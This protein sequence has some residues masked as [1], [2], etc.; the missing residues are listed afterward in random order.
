MGPIALVALYGTLII[1]FGGFD[2][3][4]RYHTVFLPAS[5]I[6]VWG[7]LLFNVEIASQVS[8]RLGAMTAGL[9]VLELA[10]IVLLTRV[11][12]AGLAAAVSLVVLA[13]QGALL[14]A[15]RRRTES[16]PR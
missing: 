12:G 16:V 3:Y 15:W 8:S 6:V 9:V 4:G 5:M 7:T 14:W 13:A 10:S 1:A 11:P 2:E